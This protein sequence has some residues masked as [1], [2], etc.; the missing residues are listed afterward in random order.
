M[1]ELTEIIKSRIAEKGPISVGEYMHLCLNHP[2]HGYYTN[3]DPFGPDGDFVTAPEVSQM[4]G[5]MVALWLMQA[6]NDQGRPEKFLLVELGPGRGTLMNDILRTAN[7]LPDF[8]QGAEIWLVENSPAM[9]RKQSAVLMGQDPH[10]AF[11][12]D[13]LPEGLPMFLVANE[14]FD[15]LPMHQFRFNDAGWQERLIEVAADGKLAFTHGQ[16]A[17]NEDLSEFFPMLPEHLYAEVSFRSEDIAAKIGD[18]IAADGGAALFIDYGDWDGAGD[19]LQAVQNHEPVDALDHPH[20]EADV[21][22]HVNFAALARAA[23]AARTEGCVPQGPF[24][25]RIGIET[26]A[27]MLINATDEDEVAEEISV[28]LNRLTHPDEMGTLFKVMGV[29][30]R[31]APTAPGFEDASLVPE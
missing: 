8:R 29:V 30:N 11:N 24:L 17:Q 5:E 20:G 19:S 1:T 13:E 3:R 14:F 23:G 16:P 15:A 27:S 10:W 28:A 9:R 25:K 21:T 31:D 7:T 4:F 6:W 12:I 18:R 2:E 22:A 26:R